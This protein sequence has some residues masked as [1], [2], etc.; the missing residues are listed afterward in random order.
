LDS[1]RRGTF[2]RISEGFERDFPVQ[3]QKQGDRQ[4]ERAPRTES[5]QEADVT[6][7][8]DLQ[9]EPPA[10]SS[11]FNLYK[12]QNPQRVEE[13][14]SKF[15]SVIPSEELLESLFASECLR[16]CETF[17]KQAT[18]IGACMTV[19]MAA[20]ASRGRRTAP[21]FAEIITLHAQHLLEFSAR[22]RLRGF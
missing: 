3:E 16:N 1:L 9:P 12:L 7:Q 10:V 2:G 18:V 5:E 19:V 21:L 15:Q 17:D 11:S 13:S 8:M 4:E 22:V 6:K 20:C 14:H